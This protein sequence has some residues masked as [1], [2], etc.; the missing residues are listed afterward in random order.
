[1]SDDAPYLEGVRVLDLTQYLAESS[2]T[3]FSNALSH[4]SES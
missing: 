4:R 2:C 3:R 1:M